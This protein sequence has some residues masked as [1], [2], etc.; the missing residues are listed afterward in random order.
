MIGL[1]QRHGKIHQQAFQRPSG[2]CLGVAIDHRDL[3]QVRDVHI[4]IGSRFFQLEGL[5]FTANFV[6]ID[7][8]IGHGIDDRDSACLFVVAAT[9]VDTFGRRVVAQVVGASWKI[10]G[11]DEIECV[12]VIDIELALF[13]GRKELLGFRRKG[14]A[15]GTRNPCNR[16]FDR[17]PENADDLD[18]VIAERG[19]KYLTLAGS[20][21]IETSLYT[22]HGNGARQDERS[23]A[24]RARTFWAAGRILCSGG[25]VLFRVLLSV[26]EGREGDAQHQCQTNTANFFH[27]VLLP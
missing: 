21:M 22:L 7:T 17:A 5:R 23:R 16:M 12:R 2:D 19:D 13:T 11:R 8:L 10:D 3:F 20:K 18:R 25:R 26:H 6:F 9:N 15:L 14:Y 24:L 4:N 27:T 1:V